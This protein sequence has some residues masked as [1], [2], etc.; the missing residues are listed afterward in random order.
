MPGGIP[1]QGGVNNTTGDQFTSGEL[2]ALQGAWR[3]NSLVVR[4]VQVPPAEYARLRFWV[5]GDTITL[6][7]GTVR[8]FEARIVLRG[9]GAMR[10]IDLV[11]GMATGWNNFQP[12]QLP[13]TGGN[14]VPIPGTGGGV[15]TP[16]VGTRPGNRPPVVPKTGGPQQQGARGQ[17]PQVPGQGQ[18]Q[19]FPGQQGQ[20]TQGIP[21]QPNV[22]AFAPGA[23][24]PEV[25]MGVYELS[26]NTWRM[27]FVLRPL[28]MN[29]N[30]NTLSLRME[31][32]RDTMLKQ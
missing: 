23:H 25:L 29:D 17:P 26:G 22:P 32:V 8:L 9:Q 2:R 7:N 10:W 13:P 16:P 14:P 15:G 4:G 27:Y 30:P 21:G 20:P 31:L 1:P 24:A 5:Q 19:P 3:I 28:T 18:N 11:L 6:Y 12:G